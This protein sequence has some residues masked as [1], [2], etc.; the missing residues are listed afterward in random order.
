MKTTAHTRLAIVAICL[1]AATVSSGP[2]SA[3]TD[4]AKNVLHEVSLE[5]NTSEYVTVAA[6]RT[7]KRKAR[8]AKPRRVQVKVNAVRLRKQ[9][10]P[11]SVS[12][13]NPTPSPS[14]IADSFSYSVEP[15]MEPDNGAP[16][17]NPLA[18]APGC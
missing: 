5:R 13:N 16:C 10:R 17:A 14:F 18:H 15:E 6:N 1:V 11:T 7:L 8:A 3:N 2:A 12:P 9:N 4:S